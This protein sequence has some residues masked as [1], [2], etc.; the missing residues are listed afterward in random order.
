MTGARFL[1]HRLWG[2]KINPRKVMVL[3]SNKV[4]AQLCWHAGRN[5]RSSLPHLFREMWQINTAKKRGDIS[6][7]SPVESKWINPS[8]RNHG[9]WLHPSNAKLHYTGTTAARCV[10]H[11]PHTPTSPAF[12]SCAAL[13]YPWWKYNLPL[14]CVPKPYK[15]KSS[16]VATF[17]H[18]Y[19][20]APLQA[21]KINYKALGL[22]FFCWL[23][24]E[25]R[26]DVKK[27]LRDDRKEE[28]ERENKITLSSSHWWQQNN[29]GERASR[30]S[31]FHHSYRP[32]FLLPSLFRH[33]TSQS[34]FS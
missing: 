12:V 11:P 30:E 29:V 28:R 6:D 3:L 22:A 2:I 26:V 13:Y 24:P 14:I 5:W 20:V 16:K 15:S 9:S 17:L 1:S 25:K 7:L 23:T 33:L 31:S 27:Q 19:Y 8:Y 18:R 4:T 10:L 34:P 32:G 21:S